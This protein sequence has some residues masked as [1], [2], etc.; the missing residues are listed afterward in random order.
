[1]QELQ[2]AAAAAEKAK[3][4]VPQRRVWVR[5]DVATQTVEPEMAGAASQPAATQTEL[6]VAGAVSPPSAPGSRPPTPP[7]PPVPSAVASAAADAAA[8]A[9]AAAA[10]LGATRQDLTAAA[11]LTAG[12]AVL[13]A[14]ATPGGG[15]GEATMAWRLLEEASILRQMARLDSPALQVYAIYHPA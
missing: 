7:P 4:A 15:G 1:V 6:Q 3:E 5:V 13:S 9:T 12:G 14:E 10:A 8:A 11:G 2:E